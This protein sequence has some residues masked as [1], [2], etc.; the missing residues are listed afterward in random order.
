MTHPKTAPAT[1]FMVAAGGIAIYSC[2]DAIMK[3]L[4]IDSGAYSA[5]L[6]RSVAGVAITG[7]VFLARR[8]P[9]PGRD[10]LNLHI[11][12][13]LAAGASI[14]LFFWGLERVPMAKSVALT[15]LAPLIALYLAAAFLGETIRRAAIAGSLV[16][17]V[18]VLVIAAGEMRAEASADSLAGTVAIVVASV[19]YAGSLILLRRQAQAADP[20][21]VTLFTSLVIG[22]VL[23]AGAPWFSGWP[24]AAQLS[25]IGVAAVLGT[26]S[27]VCLA[28]AYGRAEAQVLAPVEYT[29]FVWSAILGFAVFGERVSPFTL[30]GAAL[31]VGGCIV[32]VR[33]AMPVPMSEAGA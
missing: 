3:R 12:R 26:V 15:F 20:L 2:M 7:S 4:S 8:R 30:A 10:A 23:L 31:I 18:G 13:G 16:A 27:S 5:V 24:A 25:A 22:T 29:A 19:L 28:W 32:A 1:A 17:V 11:A 14:L 21:E 33:R 9:W 6:W